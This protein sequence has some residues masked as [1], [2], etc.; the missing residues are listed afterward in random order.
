MYGADISEHMVE[1]VLFRL[2]VPAAFRQQQLT[3]AVPFLTDS[4]AIAHGN[5][6]AYQETVVLD[7]SWK[8]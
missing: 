1:F 7:I 5:N 4:P 3:S 2:A 8:R 6:A